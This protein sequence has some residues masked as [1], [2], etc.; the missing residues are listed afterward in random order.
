[1]CHF[2]LQAP[3]TYEAVMNLHYLDQVMNESQRLLPTAPRLERMCK[4]TVQVN[5]LTVP[6]GALI[7]IP[8]HLLHMDPRYWS[9]PEQ[10]KPER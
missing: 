4:K 1:M 5:G 2:L 8:V 7:G 9:S 10:F 6:E 3:I